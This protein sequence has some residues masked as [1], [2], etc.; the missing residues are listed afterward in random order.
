MDR[1]LVN[2]L[3]RHVQAF[4]DGLK[5]AVERVMSKGWFV[6]GPECTGFEAEF[7][8]YCGTAHCIAV[9]NGTD[10]LELALR[11]VG[12]GS[13]RRV[14]TVA[15]AGF[16][17]TIAILQ[18]GA[19]PVYVDVCEADRLMD[20]ASLEQ[21]V[22]AGEVDAIVI[23]HL[24]GLMHDVER[25]RHIADRAGIPLIEDC[26]QAHGARRGGRAAGSV[27][28]VGCFSFYPTKNLGA[29]GDGGAMVTNDSLTATRLRELR[30]YGW[31]AKYR[32]ETPG[33]GNSRL[34]EMQAAVLRA[35]LPHLDGWNARRRDI[36]RRYADTIRHS[37][38]TCPEPRG[39]ADVA[40]L[41]V[42]ETPDPAGLR[43]HLEAGGIA[44]DVHYPIP[45]HLQPAI[46]EGRAWAPLPV[47]EGLARRIVTLPCY[48]ELTNQ[49]VDR[50]AERINGW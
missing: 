9:A 31:T 39:E 15:N 42:V 43:A 14:A 47:T 18:L 50:V 35:K 6:L 20:L 2:D 48:P 11:A 8:L 45:D 40:H 21:I 36:A 4:G 30:Q 16:Y 28:H 46:A 22:D 32:V 44:T 34:D 24:F 3:G 23:T 33:G 12:M 7:A 10:A 29:L 17:A 19:V 13:G 5:E 25:A 27:G 1:I 41:Y 49:E 26:A 38:V 37:R